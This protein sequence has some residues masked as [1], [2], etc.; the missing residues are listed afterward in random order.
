MGGENAWFNEKTGE[1]EEIN[2]VTTFWN[3]PKVLVICLK[4]FSTDGRRKLQHLVNFPLTDLNLAK[5]VKGYNAKQYVYDLYGVCNHFGGVQGGHYTAF[6]KNSDGKWLHYNDTSVEIV[7]NELQIMSTSAY[8]LFYR[9][10]D[11]I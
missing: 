11:S 2:K 9:K 7:P 4:R 1:K 3:L 8:C 10:K 5:Y 6:A